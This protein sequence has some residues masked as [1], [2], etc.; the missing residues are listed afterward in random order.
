[1]ATLPRLFAVH[2]ASMDEDLSAVY[3]DLRELLQLEITAGVRFAD[4]TPGADHVPTSPSGPADVPA[5]AFAAGGD[6]QARL[7]AIAEDMRTSNRCDLRHSCTQAVPGEGDADAS[8]AFVGEAPGADEDLQGRPFVGRAGQLLDKMIVAM[9]LTREQVFITNIVRYRPPNNRQPTPEEMA[10][11]MPWIEQELAVVR[12]QVIC[13]LGGTALK[14]LL[15][16]QRLG[17]TRARGRTFDWQGIPL[18][19]TFHPSYILRQEGS[20]A[21]RAVKLQA[22]EDLKRVLALVRA[23]E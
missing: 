8:I 22:W 6:K 20:D 10:V 14:A 3:G 9:G 17:I 1:M 16:D 12:P 4:L 23:P 13:A 15:G 2:T 5:V 18:I 19:P 11:C 7:A 21:E